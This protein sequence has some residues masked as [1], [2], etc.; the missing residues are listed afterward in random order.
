MVAIDHWRW[1]ALSCVVTISLAT[2]TSPAMNKPSRFLLAAAFAAALATASTAFALD[3]VVCIDEGDFV[4]PPRAPAP[5]ARDAGLPR[6]VWEG[7]TPAGLDPARPVL[8]MVHGLNGDATS[9]YGPTEY[10]GD[11]DMYDAAHAAGYKVFM[12]DLWDAGGESQTPLRNG[13]LLSDQI[14]WITQYWG[15]ERVNVLAHSKGGPDSNAAAVLFGAPIDSIVTL[16]GA[17][18][19]SPLADLAQTDWLDWLS[20]LLGFNDAGTKFLQTGC[21]NLFRGF[22]DP[23]PRN[24]ALSFYTTAG[25][26]WG[27][28]LSAL[29]IGGIYL[30]ATCPG[31]SDNDGLVCVEGA[32]HPLAR[33]AAGAQTGE[34]RLVWDL[35]GPDFELDHDNIRMGNAF[36]DFFWFWEPDDCYVPVFDS[37]EPYLGTFHA[38][39]NAP[40][41]ATPPR[42]VEPA[43]AED[44][45]RGAV[46][47]G[48]AAGVIVRGGPIGAA[49]AEAR[50]P[51]EPGV[52]ALRLRLM[53]ATSTTAIAVVDP[54]GRR[55]TLPVPQPTR[56]AIVR[57]SFSTGID[58]A[59]PASGE[60]RVQFSAMTRDAYALIAGIEGGV[61]L[62]IRSPART[63]LGIGEGIEFELNGQA[64]AVST[65]AKIRR[66]SVSGDS[67]LI[68]DTRLGGL[69]AKRLRVDAAGVY[70][71]ALSIRGRTEGGAPFE[72]SHVISAG[73]R[74]PRAGVM[75]P[76]ACE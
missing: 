11:S 30:F 60:W 58:V 52:D 35:G 69:G 7:A 9:W 71:V 29:E 4:A 49:G 1:W 38:G 3:P 76:E 23:R 16:S 39:G 54:N 6:L 26:G 8:V 72:R 43:P 53:M 65:R 50:F 18:Y 56:D 74:D 67:R 44:A 10:Y 61:A 21:M 62:S 15:T 27:P 59:D 42:P 12:V 33:D 68:S 31:S 63:A 19:G 41:P 37:V 47:A 48:V 55:Y 32:K 51:V 24:D 20:E 2:N 13:R 46:T 66:I 17:H 28:F 70:N 45:A 25:T 75:L 36:L 14:R 40:T 34:H 57:G 73:V 5:V 64:K 22:I